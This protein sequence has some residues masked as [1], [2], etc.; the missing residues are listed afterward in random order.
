[1]YII[2]FAVH[3]LMIIESETQSR[4]EASGCGA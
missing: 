4:D 1:M 2:L 3:A